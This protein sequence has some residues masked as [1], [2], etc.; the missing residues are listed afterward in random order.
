[1][2]KLRLIITPEAADVLIQCLT[3]MKEA[4]E[5]NRYG[6]LIISEDNSFAF[7]SFV[8]PEDF[9]LEDGRLFVQEDEEEEAA[10]ER[11][12]KMLDDFL[13]EL[14]EDEEEYKEDKKDEDG[15]TDI[16][17]HII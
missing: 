11:I 5:E 10:K 14:E 4:G 17:D 2:S 8:A 12:N 15:I 1:M 13:K 9:S 16:Q 7:G 6:F 3:A